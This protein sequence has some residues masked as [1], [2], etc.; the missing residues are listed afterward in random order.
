MDTM[1]KNIEKLKSVVTE[2]ASREEFVHN[3]WFIKWHIEIVEHIA[4]QLTKHYPEADKNIVTVIAW[5]HDYGKIV[6]FAKQYDYALVDEGKNLLIE[7]GFEPE[8]AEKVSANIKTLDS[9]I[10][11][12][13]ANIETQI[14]SSAD[15]CSHLVG[16]FISL[17]WWEN[18]QKNY[19]EIMSENTRK[20]SVDWEN[21]VTLKEARDIYQQMHDNELHKAQGFIP[22]L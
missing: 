4:L 2:K 8:F 1:E 9:K 13:R 22:S 3:K 17:Y 19:K 16:P 12:D 5:M 7:I 18:P 10:D 14:V 11:L 6:N 15:G 20:L 21:K